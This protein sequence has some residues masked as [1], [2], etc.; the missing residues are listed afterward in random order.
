MKFTALPIEEDILKTNEIQKQPTRYYG[1]DVLRLWGA[2]GVILLHFDFGALDNSEVANAARVLCRWIVPY[3]FLASGYFFGMNY[4][5]QGD[6]AFKKTLLNVFYITVLVNIIYFPVMIF[7]KMQNNE[8]YELFTI[9]A[10]GT[11]LH[12]WF[13]HSLI[14]GYLTLWLLV[15]KGKESFFFP[16]AMIILL[17]LIVI[18]FLL[19]FDVKI[20]AGFF[21]NFVSIPLLIIGFKLAKTSFA[22][23][24]IP[25][26]LT[27][28]TL[29]GGLM[30]QFIEAYFKFKL[31]HDPFP[32]PPYYSFGVFITTFSIFFIAL[33]WKLK[34]ETKAA[35]FGRRY[36]LPIYLY[37][38]LLNIGLFFIWDQL[39]LPDTI[40]NIFVKYIFIISLNFLIIW[41]LDKTFPKAYRF[42]TGS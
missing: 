9:F 22:E 36:A 25:I 33:N 40:F 16:L 3:F 31:S 15:Y 34:T 6:G 26:K 30:L 17:S 12:L 7:Q 10:A 24:K 27:L 2:F 23:K 4:A 29:L 32:R 20:N 39:H 1:V 5:K 42:L 18:G 35:L 28:V 8:P 41:Q 38:P 21:R 14:L 37:H 11:Y 13:L 19:F